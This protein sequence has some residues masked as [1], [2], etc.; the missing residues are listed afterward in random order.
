MA[1]RLL[2][3]EKVGVVASGRSTVSDKHHGLPQPINR[4]MPASNIHILEL[5]CHGYGTPT[6]KGRSVTRRTAVDVGET[7]AGGGGMG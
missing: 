6:R 5:Y 3:D 2:R 7:G 4:L 1:S